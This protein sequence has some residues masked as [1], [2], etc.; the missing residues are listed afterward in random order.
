MITNRSTK[1]YVCLRCQR[2]LE[3]GRSPSLSTF[4]S[5]EKLKFPI[6][7]FQST[8]TRFPTEYNP[9]D[10]KA[11]EFQKHNDENQATY[12]NK[13]GKKVESVEQIKDKNGKTASIIVLR[14]SILSTH[15]SK[16]KR[17]APEDAPTIDILG[18]LGHE[19]SFANINE[20]ITNIDGLRPKEEQLDSWIEFNQLVDE[21]ANGFT[22]V[23]LEQYF[24]KFCKKADN[25]NLSENTPYNCTD[26][27]LSVTPWRPDISASQKYFDN[28]PYRGYLFESRTMKQRL[29]ISLIRECWNVELLPVIEGVGQFE[30]KIRADILEILLSGKPLPLQSFYDDVLTI[31]GEGLEVFWSRNV[32]RI[33]TTKTRKYRIVQEIEKLVKRVKI[34]NVSLG[35]LL[36][37]F[38]VQQKNIQEDEQWIRNIFHDRTLTQLKRLTGVT[39]RQENNRQISLGAL[40]DND[41]LEDPVNAARRLLL[42]ARPPNYVNEISLASSDKSL[43]APLSYCQVDGLNWWCKTR[44]WYRWTNPIHK[45]EHLSREVPTK[46]SSSIQFLY[47]KNKLKNKMVVILP[48][49]SQIADKSTSEIKWSTEYSTSTFVT[50][51][52]LIH[53]D[54]DPK[55]QGPPLLNSRF[56]DSI[57]EFS[58]HVPNISRLLSTAKFKKTRGYDEKAIIRFLPNP[59]LRSKGKNRKRKSA[60]SKVLSSIPPVEFHCSIG[61]DKRAQFAYA[62]AIIHQNYTDIMLPQETVDLRFH[63]RTTSRLVD[64]DLPA[65]ADFFQKSTLDLNPNGNI[66]MPP[67]I[68]LPISS[69]ICKSVSRN[70]S[71]VSL[72][73]SDKKLKKF[74]HMTRD[75]EYL[76]SGFEVRR[77]LIFMYDSWHLEYVYI[78]AGKTGGVRGEL[79]LRPIK[80][81]K[82]VGDQE[83]IDFGLELAC[84]LTSLSTPDMT[85]LPNISKIDVIR[86]KKYFPVNESKSNYPRTFLYT[87]RRISTDVLIDENAITEDAGLL[88][89]YE[90]VMEFEDELDDDVVCNENENQD[91]S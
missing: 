21:L 91:Q 54:L 87:P 68:I 35:D 76:F 75:V 71:N 9:N 40:V 70:P 24:H 85:R 43:A 44:S 63:Q 7:R 27:I 38:D 37:L 15:R 28:D 89:D 79:S 64:E 32:I 73:V 13:L 45:E 16:P 57:T 58:S 72:G 10:D 1:L 69:H 42:T 22:T 74:D 84:R 36:S 48:P 81:K 53:T 86:I 77:K 82:G 67:S 66:N 47:E 83:F 88:P 4:N 18:Q 30:I 90:E 34:L 51:G 59:Y 19:A 20:V 29:A 2:I 6:K 33:T 61:K 11:I 65:I 39:I 23:Q 62:D 14:D 17:A 60:S 55:F 41:F 31:D 25:E 12:K 3:N 52:A 26:L 50:V 56:D 49:E 46:E 80:N 78:D 5:N 8:L